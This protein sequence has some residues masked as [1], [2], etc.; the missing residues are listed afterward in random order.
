[1]GENL[2]LD[3]AIQSALRMRKNGA[4]FIDVGGE[5]TRPG[6][7]K[8]DPKTEIFKLMPIIQ[9]LNFRKI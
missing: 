8:V 1:M 4:S 7:D 2:N 6:A 9:K 5:S 3:I